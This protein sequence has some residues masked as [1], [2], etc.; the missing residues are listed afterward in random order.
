M[1]GLP[2]LIPKK[3]LLKH[4]YRSYSEKD[5]CI[6][7]IENRTEKEK[8]ITAYIRH[9]YRPVDFKQRKKQHINYLTMKPG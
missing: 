3:S 8:I 6:S 9:P 2:R 5:G 4:K 1:V 7:N